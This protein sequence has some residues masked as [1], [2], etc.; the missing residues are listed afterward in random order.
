MDNFGLLLS[1]R[2][3]AL[4]IG[5]NEDVITISEEGV[6]EAAFVGKSFR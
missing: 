5:K 4:M 2:I 3:P 6:H 1:I